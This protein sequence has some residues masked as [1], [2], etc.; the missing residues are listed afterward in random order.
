[1][2]GPPD[3]R[4]GPPRP[5]HWN[6]APVGA[7]SK[8]EGMSS[9]QASASSARL[10]HM[11]PEAGLPPRGAIAAKSSDFALKNRGTRAD[12]PLQGSNVSR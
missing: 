3:N 8:N 12:P 5:G 9:A 4:P 1:V 10:V 6:E 7:V 11:I 2:D